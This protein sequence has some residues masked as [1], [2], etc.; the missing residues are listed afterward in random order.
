MIEYTVYAQL[1]GEI[2]W[3]GTCAEE[4]YPAL[5][6]PDDAVVIPK[7]SDALT[8]YVE[9]LSEEIKDKGDYTLDNLPL[10]CKITIDDQVYD[11]E[12][13]PI[14]TFPVAGSYVVSVDAGVK[15]F[16][17]EFI[18]EYTPQTN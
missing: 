5:Y 12:V 9:L 18:L 11:C 1:D 2:L 13:Q 3:S 8:Q 10:P 6:V 7:E 15:Y 14:L 17:K 4:D 16:K